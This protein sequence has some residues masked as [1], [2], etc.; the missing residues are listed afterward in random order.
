[1]FT[2]IFLRHS[3]II[4][5]NDN[6]FEHVRNLDFSLLGNGARFTCGAWSILLIWG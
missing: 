1:M 4:G 3:D 6:L 5:Y 2:L